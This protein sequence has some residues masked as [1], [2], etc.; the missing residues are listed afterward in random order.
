MNVKGHLMLGQVVLGFR[1][2]GIWRRKRNAF[3]ASF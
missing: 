2:A 3:Q 1:E